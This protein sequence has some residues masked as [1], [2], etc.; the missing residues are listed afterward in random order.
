MSNSLNQK[1]FTVTVLK[2][3]LNQQEKLLKYQSDVVNSLIYVNGIYILN[4]LN[5]KEI[6]CKSWDDRQTAVFWHV[7]LYALQTNS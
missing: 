6:T 7:L 1:K 4:I 3:W 2:V 5:I